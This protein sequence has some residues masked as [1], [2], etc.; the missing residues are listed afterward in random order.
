M[1]G[2]VERGPV[3]V[4][5]GPPG[6]GKSTYAARL[7]S[8]L[9]LKYYSTGTLFRRLAAEMGISLEELNKR[10]EGSAEI[11]AKIEAK[12]MEIAKEGNVVIDS[13]LAAW[14]LVGLADLLVYVKAPLQVR[15]RRI[16]ERD[17]KE[18]SEALREILVRERSHWQ[19]FLRY[20]G[21]DLRDLTVFHLVVDTSIYGVEEVYHIIREAALLTIRKR[22]S[23]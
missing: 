17:R 4:I 10:A 11:D 13:H 23:F 9:G 18:Y 2:G 14:L 1:G 15:A 6:S 19:R 20:Y 3:I 8:E 7:A 12:T 5:S 21:V 16:A 22:K